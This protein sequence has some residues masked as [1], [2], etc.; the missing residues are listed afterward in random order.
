MEHYLSPEEINELKE[1]LKKAE[2]YER[3]DP[4]TLTL[5]GPID[6]DRSQASLAKYILD[7]YYEEKGWEKDY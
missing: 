3:G 5:D 2:P 4:E 6:F 1:A 7:M